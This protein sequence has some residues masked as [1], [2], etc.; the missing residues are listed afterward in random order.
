VSL[1][2][3]VSSSAL[4]VVLLCSCRTWFVQDTGYMPDRHVV[5]NTPPTQA[6]ATL[7]EVIKRAGGVIDFRHKFSATG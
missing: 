4:L 5:E 7:A 2:R 3:R 6:A 1:C